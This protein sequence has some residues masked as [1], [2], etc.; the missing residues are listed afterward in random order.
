MIGPTIAPQSVVK[1]TGLI[2]LEFTPDH[3]TLYPRIPR[4]F[5]ETKLIDAII[6]KEL[7]YCRGLATLSDGA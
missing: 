4:Y 3:Y 6:A 2:F 5:G 7:L 1:A